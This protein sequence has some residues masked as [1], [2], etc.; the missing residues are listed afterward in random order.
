MSDIAS[1]YSDILSRLSTQSDRQSQPVND[2]RIVRLLGAKGMMMDPVAFHAH[3]LSPEGAAPRPFGDYLPDSLEVT[4]DVEDPAHVAEVRSCLG[5]GNPMEWFTP[6]AMSGVIKSTQEVKWRPGA[7]DFVDV[8]APPTQS[9]TRELVDF[10]TRLALLRTPGSGSL[11]VIVEGIDGDGTD[12]VI[13]MSRDLC[14]PYRTAGCW[15]ADIVV[16]RGS[17]I[18]H[19]YNT[20][21]TNQALTHVL[22]AALQRVTD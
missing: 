6:I 19:T 22:S 1:H 11:A 13:G 15:S 20:R 16:Q 18:N 14:R 12:A 9:S 2:S 5:S 4:V 3:L 7:P 17:K 21:A 10:P 8:I